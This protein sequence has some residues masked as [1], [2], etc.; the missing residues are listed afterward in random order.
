M[1]RRTLDS[2]N[3]SLVRLTQHISVAKY[4]TTRYSNLLE[5]LWKIMLMTFIIYMLWYWLHMNWIS[6]KPFRYRTNWVPNLLRGTPNVYM[7]IESRKIKNIILIESIIL[8]FNTI[9]VR[10]TL[11]KTLNVFNTFFFLLFSLT[12]DYVCKKNIL[13]YDFKCN[14]IY[15]KFLS[16]Q[17]F[18]YSNLDLCFL[19]NSLIFL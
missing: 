6:M 17:L 18:M 11:I 13:G 10:Q 4:I 2:R 9:W 5:I 15:R 14:V 7:L 16:A 8:C 1:G 12:E 19:C 3:S